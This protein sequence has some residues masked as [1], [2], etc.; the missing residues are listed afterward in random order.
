[1]FIGGLGILAVMW[2]D[3][4]SHY[5]GGW[6]TDILHT[7][8]SSETGIKPDFRYARN[9][10]RDGEWH[11]AIAAIRHELTK[12][13]KNFEGL[14]LLSEIYK[15]LAKPG[16]AIKQLNTILENPDATPDQKGGAQRKG[17]LPPTATA[18][19]RSGVL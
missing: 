15:D 7:D 12:D 11:K 6:I 13:P 8:V 4:L 9:H 5:T 1:M 2:S 16:E 17:E 10:R 18:F 19:G 3:V 14:L